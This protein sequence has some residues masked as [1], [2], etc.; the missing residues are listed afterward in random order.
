MRRTEMGRKRKKYFGVICLM[1]MTPALV[2]SSAA[3]AETPDVLKIEAELQMPAVNV[4]EIPLRQETVRDDGGERTVNVYTDVLLRTRVVNKSGD[5]VR[6]QVPLCDYGQFW[7]SDAYPVVV[8]GPVVCPVQEY[9][10]V[11]LKPG[12][13][14]DRSL[15]V[16]FTEESPYGDFTFRIGYR[17]LIEGALP[18]E[19]EAVA[20]RPV[21]SGPLKLVLRTLRGES[22][23]VVMDVEEVNDLIKAK[24]PFEIGVRFRNLTFEEQ[25]IAFPACDRAAAF[26][27]DSPMF[28]VVTGDCKDEGVESVVIAPRGDLKFPLK[29]SFLPTDYK[30][31]VAFLLR[32]RPPGEDDEKNWLN[33]NSITLTAE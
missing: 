8:K 26:V 16:G 6:I 19:G 11:T 13:S 1:L 33:G 7:V 31:I 17:G 2:F 21:W 3:G 14:Y 30:G 10:I 18:D 22:G 4:V 27:I 20:S 12:E 9:S 15:V 32:Y 29:I 23:P 24:E 28:K 25:E 5:P